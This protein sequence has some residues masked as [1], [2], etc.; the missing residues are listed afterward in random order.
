MPQNYKQYTSFGYKSY[1]IFDFAIHSPLTYID[2]TH[3]IALK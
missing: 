1:E 3:N 2:S